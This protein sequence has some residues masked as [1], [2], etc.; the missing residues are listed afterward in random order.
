MSAREMHV[1]PYAHLISAS[2]ISGGDSDTLRLTFSAHDVEIS[3]RNL[4]ALLLALQ[5]F[6]VKWIRAM[7][8]RYQ[9]LEAGENGAVLRIHVRELTSTQ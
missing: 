3:G 1:L 8:N 5:E 6:S 7:P 9:L 2:L 4:R